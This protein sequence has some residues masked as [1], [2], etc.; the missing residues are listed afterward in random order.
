MP[1]RRRWMLPAALALAG[2]LVFGWL[3]VATIRDKI[4][5]HDAAGAEMVRVRAADRACRSDMARRDPEAEAGADVRG[6]VRRPIFLG[7]GDDVRAIVAPGL[8]GCSASRPPP[9]PRAAPASCRDG[10]AG[11]HGEVVAYAARYNRRLLSL[12]PRE[13]AAACR[14]DRGDSQQWA[15]R[16]LTY[17]GCAG[18]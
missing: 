14:G 4:A 15:I 1:R 16:H 6:G 7:I 11:A 18:R 13:V 8:D 17:H 9:N 10:L 2:A 3:A 5:R 12:A